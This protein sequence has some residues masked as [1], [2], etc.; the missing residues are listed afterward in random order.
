M[1]GTVR[2]SGIVND[3]TAI[4]GARGNVLAFEPM[5]YRPLLGTEGEPTIG[6]VV[7]SNTSGP[8]RVQASSETT[9]R[10]INGGKRLTSSSPG[11]LRAS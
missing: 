7:A 1:D 3:L 2:A 5:D 9:T 8:R 6:G 4:V 10:R 11:S